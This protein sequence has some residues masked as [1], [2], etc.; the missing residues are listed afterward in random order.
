MSAIKAQVG[1]S[2]GLWLAA[3]V[4]DSHREETKTQELPSKH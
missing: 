1:H 2:V 3:E 4:V